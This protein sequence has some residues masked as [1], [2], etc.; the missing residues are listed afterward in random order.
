[1]S[2]EWTRKNPEKAAIYRKEWRKNNI[3]R[4]RENDRRRYI[5]DKEKRKILNQKWAENNRE[6]IRQRANAKNAE[7]R[8]DVLQAYGNQCACCGEKEPKFLAIDHI[9]G[10]GNKHRQSVGASSTFYRWLKRNDYPEGYQILCHNCKMAKGFY[11][12]CSHQVHLNGE[13]IGKR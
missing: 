13:E 12:E 7:I 3:E 1:M 2:K 8:I 10:G 6:L 9:N 5:R 4:E 11:G